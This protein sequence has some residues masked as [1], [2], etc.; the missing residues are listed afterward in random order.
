MGVDA[1]SDEELV[2]LI[3]GC[4]SKREPVRVLAARIVEEAG[5]RVTD[6]YGNIPERFDRPMKGQLCSNGLVH[7]DVLSAL[8]LGPDLKIL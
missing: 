6:M 5:G 8:A 2:A 7:D 1:L 4:G 3:L